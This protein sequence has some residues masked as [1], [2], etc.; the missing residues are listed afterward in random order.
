[1]HVDEINPDVLIFKIKQQS[2]SLKS[3]FKKR[4]IG[5]VQFLWGYLVFGFRRPIK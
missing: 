5:F 3:A 2:K 1:V 4:V